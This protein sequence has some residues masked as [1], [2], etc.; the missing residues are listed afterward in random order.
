MPPSLKRERDRERERERGEGED[1]ETRERE[2]DRGG[3]RGE[4]R[5]RGGERGNLY[6]SLSLSSFLFSLSLSRSPLSLSPLLSF[7]LLFLLSLSR[8][9]SLALLGERERGCNHS[10]CLVLM[11]VDMSLQDVVVMRAAQG[12]GKYHD[13]LKV[14]QCEC[15]CSTGSSEQRFRGWSDWQAAAVVL[16]VLAGHVW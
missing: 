11:G 7:F 3:G 12:C 1:R 4:D 9:L 8:S 5:E 13:R 10:N 16:Y 6:L 2:R 14:H 15:F